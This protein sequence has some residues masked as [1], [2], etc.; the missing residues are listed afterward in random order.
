[1]YSLAL[2]VLFL[3][4]VLVLK[5]DWIMLFDIIVMIDFC[6]TGIGEHKVYFP[7]LKSID[8]RIKLAQELGTGLSIWEIGQG[9]DYFYDLLWSH[10]HYVNSIKRST[11]NTMFEKWV[12]V[13]FFATAITHIRFRDFRCWV[14][15]HVS[16]SVFRVFSQ[17][18]IVTELLYRISFWEMLSSL[19]ND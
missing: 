6:R 10:W 12:L 16:G 2:L 11:F 3:S 9:L 17:I 15:C 7:T 8:V 4:K 5:L 13:Y 19:Q 1:M 14:F 18:M